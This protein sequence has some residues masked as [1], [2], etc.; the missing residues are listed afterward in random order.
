M[1]PDYPF[2]LCSPFILTKVLIVNIIWSKKLKIFVIDSLLLAEALNNASM[3]EIKGLDER[4]NGL[5]QLLQMVQSLK[6]SQAEMAQVLFMYRNT[7][8]ELR[9][10]SVLVERSKAR[11]YIFPATTLQIPALWP[12]GVGLINEQTILV[13]TSSENSCRDWSERPDRT[14]GKEPCRHKGS[15]YQS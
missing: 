7:P 9:S 15:G 12:T 8:I 13:R 4:L 14:N 10:K 3:K 6:Q 11:T 1:N 2:C 5:Q